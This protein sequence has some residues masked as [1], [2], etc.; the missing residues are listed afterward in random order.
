MFRLF[1]LSDMLD[2]VS[3]LKEHFDFA[4]RKQTNKPTN[5]QKNQRT[6]NKEQRTKN[7]INKPT[8]EQTNKR[9][10]RLKPK[11]FPQFLKQQRHLCKFVDIRNYPLEKHQKEVSSQALKFSVINYIGAAIG[12]VS[13]L[14]IY[15]NDKE[16]LGIIRYI[17]DGAQILMAF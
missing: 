6:K 11:T 1:R 8:K 3:G 16:F 15:P 10:K 4:Q 7:Q 14:F 12:I 9:A 5:Q 13:T 2:F 17:F